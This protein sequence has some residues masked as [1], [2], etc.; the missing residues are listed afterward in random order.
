MNNKKDFGEEFGFLDSE[1]ESL[2]GRYE[3]MLAQGRASYFDVS[4][5]ED[6]ID[7]YSDRF[8]LKKAM[9]AIAFAE[10]VHPF[11]PSIRLIKA[12][13]FAFTN[14]PRKALSI[15][16][17]LEQSEHVID[18]DP[19][20]LKLSKAYALILTGKVREGLAVQHDLLNSEAIDL[21]DVEQVLTIV[22]NGLL[23][24]DRCEEA[25]RNL[26]NFRDK[27][28]RSPVLLDCL[29]NAYVELDDLESA[30]ACYKKCVEKN[31]F[32]PQMWCNLA[33]VLEGVDEAMQAYDYALLLDEKMPQAYCG[34]A[35]LLN[36]TG[37]IEEAG[38]LLLKGVNV[39]PYDMELFD[40]LMEHYEATLDYDTALLLCRTMVEENPGNPHL[41]LSL[42]RVCCYMELFEEALMACDTSALIDEDLSADVC[43]VKA[44]IY[45]AMGLPEKELEMYE[46]LLKADKHNLLLACEVGMLYES[47]GE[48]DVAYRVYAAAINANPDQPHL[49]LR[50][51]MLLDSGNRPEDAYRYA[52]RAVALDDRCSDAWYL[53]ATLQ[54][55]R[56]EPKEMLR[57]L[58][59]A[60]AGREHCPGAIEMLYELVV[61]DTPGTT[62]LL[63][64]AEKR[65]A[66]AP[67]A[68][69]HCYMAALHFSLQDME[70]CLTCLER[71]LNINARYSLEFFF[72]LC[73]KAKKSAEVK[74][75]CRLYKKAGNK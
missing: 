3:E 67:I 65:C 43:E 42:A 59:R 34:K 5:F 21:F 30:A 53:L 22:T 64:L 40:M 16:F 63:K 41:W 55:R 17:Q 2:I 12:S 75:L 18:L 50:M 35:E 8:E 37:K 71:A 29:A 54:R 74:T 6:I 23:E 58:K 68:Q 15:I 19:F 36:E 1:E 27:V 44:S 24:Q 26:K 10:K 31:P 72:K 45:L 4:E 39:C 51:S 38:E 14:K 33:D 11:S 13:L 28:E 46:K 52:Q 69:P 57:S 56:G 9:Q 25:I 47:R 66:G 60:L 48:L 7:Y 20:R 70:K 73:P 61:E 32:D 62:P 49:Y